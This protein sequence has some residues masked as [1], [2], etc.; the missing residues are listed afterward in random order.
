[1]FLW[2]PLRCLKQQTFYEAT[3]MFFYGNKTNETKHVFFM[4]TKQTKQNMFFFFFFS[5]LEATNKPG[6]G[7]FRLFCLEDF[8][9]GTLRKIRFRFLSNLKEYDRSD[10]FPSDYEQNGIHDHIPFNL[11]GIIIIFFWGVSFCWNFLINSSLFI[12]CVP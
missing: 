9:S 7:Q 5:L 12:C 6:S 1:M 4:E 8:F 3:N 2:S 11:K 10:S